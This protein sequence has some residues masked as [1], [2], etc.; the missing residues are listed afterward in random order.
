M[1]TV[2]PTKGGARKN[3]GRKPVEDKK[4]PV[5]LFIPKSVIEHHGGADALKTALI[6][7]LKTLTN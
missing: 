4:Q 3:S 1:Q 6:N 7:K 2:K 5:T